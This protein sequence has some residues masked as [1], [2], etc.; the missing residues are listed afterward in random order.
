MKIDQNDARHGRKPFA[1]PSFALAV[2][3]LAS[4]LRVKLFMSFEF[5]CEILCQMQI[6]LFTNRRGGVRAD[7]VEATL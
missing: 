6:Y 1:G 3:N 5:V 7:P 4:I 2:M